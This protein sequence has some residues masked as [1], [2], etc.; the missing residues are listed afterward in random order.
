MCIDSSPRD[1]N[2]NFIAMM[3]ATIPIM[4]SIPARTT[5]IT[6]ATYN[7]MEE[8]IDISL[9]DAMSLPFLH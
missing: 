6:T 5:L 9:I 8:D 2:K 1:L 4:P 3:A 7:G